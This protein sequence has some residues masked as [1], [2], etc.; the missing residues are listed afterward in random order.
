LGAASA[1]AGDC[2]ARLV[3]L[4][5]CGPRF[6]ISLKRSTQNSSAIHK[7]PADYPICRLDDRADH[8]WRACPRGNARHA[9]LRG[10]GR[11]PCSAPNCARN[12]GS[13]TGERRTIDKRHRGSEHARREHHSSALRRYLAS[14][15]A[16]TGFSRDDAATASSTT[17]CAMTEPSWP[18][19]RQ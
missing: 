5:E 13:A 10:A 18:R 12:F 17:G 11:R 16:R 6:T 1:W 3:D 7:L 9:S 8:G 2:G 15:L 4:P 19:A 14:Q